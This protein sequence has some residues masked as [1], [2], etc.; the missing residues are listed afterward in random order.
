MN[1][2]QILFCIDYNLEIIADFERDIQGAEK[3]LLQ[4]R[5]DYNTWSTDPGW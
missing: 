4:W 3:Q 2:L 1:K 5:R